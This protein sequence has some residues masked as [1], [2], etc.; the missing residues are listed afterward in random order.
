[1]HILFAHLDDHFSFLSQQVL[2]VC[3]AEAKLTIL[4]DVD[5]SSQ[6]IKN[7]NVDI[8]ICTQ[9]NYQLFKL[10]KKET[11]TILITNETIY[12]YSA[13]LQNEEHNLID[14]IIGAIDSKWVIHELRITLQKLITKDIFGISFYLRPKTDIKT[15]T[16]D[17]V[18]ER[19]RHHSHVSSYMDRQKAP[20]AVVRHCHAITE[21]LL[22]NALFDAPRAAGFSHLTKTNALPPDQRPLIEYGFDGKIIAISVKDTYGAFPKSIFFNYLKKSLYKGDADKILDTKVEGAGIGLFKILSYCHGII[23]NQNAGLETEVIAL[24]DSEKVERN[25][26]KVPRSIHYFDQTLSSLD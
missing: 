8:F 20:P 11:T 15:H 19:H 26:Q 5:K 9:A 23:C 10:I 17:L 13:D 16:I 14:H 3:A 22:M 4:K 25:I 2:Q 24:I 6:F 7:N 21:E 18:E 12:Q 1:M